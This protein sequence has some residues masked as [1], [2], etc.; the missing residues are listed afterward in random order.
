[1]V[2][3]ILF[4]LGIWPTARNWAFTINPLWFLVTLIILSI[5]PLIKYFKNY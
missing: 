5:R 4:L 2:A 3:G 1:M